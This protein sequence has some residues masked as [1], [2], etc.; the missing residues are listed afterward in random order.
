MQCK[1]GGSA[2]MRTHMVKTLAG[3]QRWWSEAQET[4]LPMIV[5][6]FECEG[7]GRTKIECKPRPPK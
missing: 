6:Q 2:P 4:D 1:C 3:A 7:C 5:C